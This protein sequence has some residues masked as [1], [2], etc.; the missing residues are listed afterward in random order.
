MKSLTQ[1]CIYETVFQPRL[2]GGSGC[3]SL[4]IEDADGERTGLGRDNGLAIKSFHLRSVRKHEV[5]RFSAV[6]GLT[7]TF[8]PFHFQRRRETLWNAIVS[9]K[10]FV[11]T[12]GETFFGCNWL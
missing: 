8:K 5:E 3:R 2:S 11:C 7:A 6:I 12:E 4:T 10:A 1:Y 9:L